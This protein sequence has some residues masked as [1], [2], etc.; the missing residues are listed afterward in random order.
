MGAK[1]VIAS[2]C[3]MT[4]TTSRCKTFLSVTTRNVLMF[5]WFNKKKR[6]KKK[7]ERKE[8]RG[9]LAEAVQLYVEA[10]LGQEAA[11]VLLLQADGATENS[12]RLSLCAQAARL[13]PEGEHGQLARERKAR[14]GFDLAVAGGGLPSELRQA[15][16]ALEK[17]KLWHQAAE[18]YRLLDDEAGEVRALKNGGLI[19][20]LESRLSDHGD[21]ARQLRQRGQLL[22][23]LDDLVAVAERRKAIE[24]A[25]AWLREQPDDEVSLKLRHVRSQLVGG[26][27][28]ALMV[29]GERRVFV[30][31]SDFRIGRSEAAVLVASQAVSRQHL[32]LFR[33]ADG[34]A[35]VEDLATR[36]GTTLAGARIRGRLAV[37]SGL[38]LTLADQVPCSVT[39]LEATQPKGPLCIRVGGETYIAPLG[40]PLSLFGWELH[41][42]H[43]GEDRYL[44]LKTPAGSQPPHSE[45][46]QLGSQIELAVGDNLRAERDGPVVLSVPTNWQLGGA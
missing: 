16:T 2:C 12:T 38:A 9:A 37:G 29:R 1:W 28:I 32:R 14:I 6:L 18:A 4:L 20:A 5:G 21:E 13:D 45:H 24:R 46:Y 8:L 17:A 26:P 25:A 33:D 22:R 31:A 41:D 10:E 40:P 35:Y 34:V 42:A 39:P 11:R 23:E 3:G 15:A 36:N 19:E 44:V 43:E 27:T 7:A 30:L